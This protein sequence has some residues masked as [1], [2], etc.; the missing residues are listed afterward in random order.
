MLKKA[1]STTTRNIRKGEEEGYDYKYISE[2]KIFRI[3]K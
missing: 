3:K 1:V 2:K